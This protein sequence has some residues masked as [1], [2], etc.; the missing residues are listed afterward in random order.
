MRRECRE[1]FPRHRGWAIPT[2]II[3]LRNNVL[4]FDSEPLPRSNQRVTN[5]KVLI[6]E[7]YMSVFA[8]TF[9]NKSTSL[10]D[11]YYHSHSMGPLSIMMTWAL[12]QYEDGILP[13]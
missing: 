11:N 13:V 5:Q 10:P 2:V 7:A 8:Y 9:D 12:I 4:L 1:R 3:D 6:G